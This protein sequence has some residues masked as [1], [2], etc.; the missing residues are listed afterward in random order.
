[1]SALV[2]LA[3]VVV[4]L[5][6]LEHFGRSYAEGEIAARLRSAGMT[7]DIQVTVG[8]AWWRP[9]VLP[10][11]ATGTLD[12]VEIRIREGSVSGIPVEEVDYVLGGIDGD[13]SLLNGTV[14]VRSIDEGSVS[15]RVLAETIGESLA[16]PIAIR[17]G[18]VVVGAEEAPAELRVSGDNLVID[19]P[20][21]AGGAPIE[22]VLADP[23][24]LPC[25]PEP[26]VVDGA[27]QLDC[28]G[29]TLPGI[30]EGPLQGDTPAPDGVPPMEELPPPQSIDRPGG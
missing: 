6:A 23:Y 30:L 3:M 2:I 8:R 10:A 20:D 1:M 12:Q 19:A 15:M 27:I 7:G 18:R 25:R 17:D 4:G 26:G 9:S 16:T 29:D 5:A 24:I 13:L 11:V 22:L 28:T 21:R 14:D